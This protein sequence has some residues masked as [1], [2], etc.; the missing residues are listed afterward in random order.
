MTNNTRIYND[1]VDINIDNMKK[2]YDKRAGNIENLTNIY[3]S[4]LGNDKNLELINEQL[5]IEKEIILPKLQIDKESKVI[6]IGCGIGR[7][8]E[9]IIDDCGFYYGIDFSENMIDVAK[10]RMLNL[11]KSN[12]EFESMTFQELSLKAGNSG[13]FNR[14]IISGILAVINDS[15]LIDCLHGLSGLLE[16]S[17]IIFVWEPCGLEQRLT[18]RDFHSEALEDKHNVIYR[19]VKEYDKL[20]SCFI[21]NGFQEVFKEYYSSLGGTKTYIDSDKIYYI[22]KRND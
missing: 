21:D 17:S 8:A 22:F 20:F 13:K 3:T 19:T 15:D 9:E 16:Q 18:L 2:F 10:Q 14:V 7:W 11:G 12:Y 6:D 5:R 4:V 1:V